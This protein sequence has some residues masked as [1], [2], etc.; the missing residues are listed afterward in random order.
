MST[1]KDF[2]KILGVDKNADTETIKKAY[3]KL[4]LKWHPDR[5]SNASEKEQKEA[6][7]K[8][9][10]ISE[11]HDVLS[12]PEKRQQYDNGGMNFDFEDIFN[13]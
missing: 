6:E 2:Y 10:E 9:K 5:F 4:A 7:E 12:N 3:K 13:H 11:A 1:E 8:F